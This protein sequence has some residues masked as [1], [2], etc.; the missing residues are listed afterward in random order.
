VSQL[1]R[2]KFRRVAELVAEPSNLVAHAIRSLGSSDDD[3]IQV[4]WTDAPEFVESARVPV[5]NVSWSTTCNSGV[6]SR[7]S[8]F[9]AA[10]AW[11]SLA[12][13]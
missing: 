2:A 13:A 3:R 6:R 10:D 8:W 5:T 4:L 12:V 7:R 1:G 9:L 11:V